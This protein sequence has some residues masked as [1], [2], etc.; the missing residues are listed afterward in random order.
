ME[1]QQNC[2]SF[3]SFP[4]MDS[5]SR[6]NYPSSKKFIDQSLVE[7]SRMPRKFYQIKKDKNPRRDLY[8]FNTY[9]QE[10]VHEY[11]GNGR[12]EPEQK[13]NEDMG[14][15]HIRSQL[16]NIEPMLQAQHPEKLEELTHETFSRS[17][18]SEPILVRELHLSGVDS[19]K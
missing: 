18:T 7:N 12:E 10:E 15:N 11:P 19:T 8:R 13:F 3:Y 9:Q 5:E 2:K 1:R 17:R 4:L 16:E 14:N 6:S